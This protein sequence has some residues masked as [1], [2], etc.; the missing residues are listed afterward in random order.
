MRKSL[1]LLLTGT[2]VLAGCGGWSESRINPGNWFGKSRSTPV[3]A[4]SEAETVNPLLP[5]KGRKSIFARAEKED[6]A[7]PVSTISELR[8]EPTPNGAIIYASGIASRQGAHEL[9]LRRLPDTAEDTL[10]YTFHVLYPVGPTPAGSE[11]SR[12]VRA[13]VSVTEQ[14]L[15]G[16][17]T[18]RVSG[19]ENARETRR[20]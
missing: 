17:R 6:L 11:H 4:A 9:E 3:A 2:L 15:R 16:I 12:T 1:A 14:S 7:V 18:I 5:D 10:E 20:R 13:A 19:A 8:V